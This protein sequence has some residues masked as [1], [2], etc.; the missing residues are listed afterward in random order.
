MNNLQN[1]KLI[2]LDVDGTLTDGKIYY[3]SNGNE[4]KAFDVKDGMAI[5]QASKNGI[6]IAI[7]TGR[8]SIIVEKRA[9][10]LGI[11]HIYQGINSK[12]EVIDSIVKQ[13]A[14]TLEEVIYIGDDINDLEVMGKVKYAACPNDAVKEVKEICNIVSIKNGGNG[15]VREIIEHILKKQRNWINIVEKYNGGSQ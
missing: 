11:K 14:I 10:E 9:K 8:N 15:A 2:A 4:M 12:V 3:D 6:A 13:L 1:I 7:I 5:S